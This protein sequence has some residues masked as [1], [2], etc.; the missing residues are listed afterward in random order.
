MELKSRMENKA[1]VLSIVGAKP[2]VATESNTFRDKLEEVL[3]VGGMNY[4]VD[5][6]EVT[7]IDSTGLCA[8]IG[9]YQRIRKVKGEL[10]LVGLKNSLRC[11]FS[12]TGLH[13][14]FSI[15]ENVASAVCS[16]A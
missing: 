4:I 13:Q 11:T 1:T 10:I 2:L 7:A 16:V 6:D 12:L 3:V 9:F 15:S 14:V 8:L 5:F